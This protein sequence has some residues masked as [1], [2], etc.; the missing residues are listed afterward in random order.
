MLVVQLLGDRRNLL[1]LLVLVIRVGRGERRQS[2]GRDLR[3][4]SESVAQNQVNLVARRPQSVDGLLVGQKGPNLVTFVTKFGMICIEWSLYL[5]G[6][7]EQRLSVDLDDALADPQPDVG[8]GDAGVVDFGDEN[9]LVVGVLGVA[10]LALEAAFDDHSEFLV[11][12]FADGDFL[13]LIPNYILVEVRNGLRHSSHLKTF[14]KR[15][16]LDLE[17][18]FVRSGEEGHDGRFVGGV[19]DILAVHR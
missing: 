19:S 15:I 3:G 4:V 11:G 10:G 5:V 18:H 17:L 12:A 1:L 9:A 14:R 16:M 2:V 13:E 8:G 7:A 6:G